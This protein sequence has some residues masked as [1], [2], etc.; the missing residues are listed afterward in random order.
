MNKATRQLLTIIGGFCDGEGDPK[1]LILLERYGLSVSSERCPCKFSRDGLQSCFQPIKQFKL[2][3]GLMNAIFLAFPPNFVS[4]YV[5]VNKGQEIVL[6]FVEKY[7]GT[8]S[9]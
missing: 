1:Y 8:K 5:N 7:L 9:I 6:K 4:S 2:T 3:D